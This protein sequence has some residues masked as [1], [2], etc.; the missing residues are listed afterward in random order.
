MKPPKG[1]VVDHIDGNK[2]NNTR[3]N[4]RICTQKENTW[5]QRQRRTD[6][7]KGVTLLNTGRWQA[8]IGINGRHY[9]L[10]TYSTADDAATAYRVVSKVLHG[11][12]A[13]Q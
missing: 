7:P 13:R 8:Q 10:G 1:M 4:L 2:S 12:F 9:F 5:N 11:E 3:E 6:L